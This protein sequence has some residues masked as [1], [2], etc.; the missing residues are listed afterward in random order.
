MIESRYKIEYVLPDKDA[1]KASPLRALWYLLLI[2]LVIFIVTAITYDFSFNNMSRDSSVLVEKAKV[3]IFNLGDTQQSEK[4][5]SI[6]VKKSVLPASK[7]PSIVVKE[8]IKTPIVLSTPTIPKPL[9]NQEKVIIS[10]LTSKQ[11]SQLKT[12]QKQIAE[13]TELT[14]N[15]NKLSEQLVLEQVKNQQLNSQLT[16]QEKDRI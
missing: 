1:Q 15:L 7:S 5:T 6:V 4:Q 9:I 13:N 2:P 3:H 16:E 14:Q 8:N 12:I 10:E 11:E